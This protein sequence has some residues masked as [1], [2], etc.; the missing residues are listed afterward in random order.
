MHIFGN[1]DTLEIPSTL[2]DTDAYINNSW[3]LCAD[4]VLQRESIDK[5][6]HLTHI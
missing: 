4:K 6:P 3:P 2:I 5:D 1:I